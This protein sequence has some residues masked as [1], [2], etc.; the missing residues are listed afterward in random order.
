M[1]RTSSDPLKAFVT[2]RTSLEAERAKLTARLAEVE[3]ALGTIAASGGAKSAAKGTFAPRKRAQN[4]LSLKEAVLKAIEKKPLT[5]AEILAAV[6]KLGYKFTAKNPTNSLN[7]LLYGKK[8]K[9]KTQD[10]KFSLA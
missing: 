10:G 4:E 3:A 8:P 2:L 1:A 6:E 7:T 9:F 5:K